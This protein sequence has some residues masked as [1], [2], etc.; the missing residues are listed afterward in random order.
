[1]NKIRRVF[2]LIITIALVLGLNIASIHASH[3]IVD[4]NPSVDDEISDVVGKID[5]PIIQAKIMDLINIE[6]L[7]V[8]IVDGGVEKA[9]L[10]ASKKLEVSDKQAMA[11]V[12]RL[13]S[14]D[15]KGLNQEIN[16]KIQTIIN[17][18]KNNDN[19][20]ILPSSYEILEKYG[21]SKDVSA[22]KKESQEVTMTADA[23]AAELSVLKPQ[24]MQAAKGYQGREFSTTGYLK[25]GAGKNVASYTLTMQVFV[26]SKIKIYNWTLYH[27]G[28]ANRNFYRFI[29][30]KVISQKLENSGNA[31]YVESNCKYKKTRPVP[32]LTPAYNSIRLTMRC[33]SGFKLKV[34]YRTIASYS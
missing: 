22:L 33:T 16:D 29:S 19:V 9:D 14:L 15:E 13:L 20:I 32:S 31:L 27:G 12:Q 18:A 10:V 24:A 21:F 8:D 2:I 3:S 26:N 4:L 6:Y 5:N 25:N 17:K 1:M 28:S 11:D 7:E 23:S 34:T 30:K